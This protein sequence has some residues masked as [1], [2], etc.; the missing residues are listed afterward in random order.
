[1]LS[2]APGRTAQHRRARDI[3]RY[4]TWVSDVER[5]SQVHFTLKQSALKIGV[6]EL[7]DGSGTVRRLQGPIQV[8]SNSKYTFSNEHSSKKGQKM[9]SAHLEALRPT[10]LLENDPWG[11]FISTTP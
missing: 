7:K 11:R 10:V 5:F 4:Y 8:T 9:R 6:A 3:P 2:Q 1:M